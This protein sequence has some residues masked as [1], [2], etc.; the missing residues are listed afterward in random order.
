M[1]FQVVAAQIRW[2]QYFPKY[3][4]CFS[5]K[6]SHVTTYGY[7]V[8]L[9]GCSCEN[10]NIK[11]WSYHSCNQMTG[12]K[13]RLYWGCIYG[14]SADGAI[15]FNRHVTSF[16]FCILKAETACNLIAFILQESWIT[17]TGTKPF[18]QNQMQGHLSGFSD[19]SAGDSHSQKHYVFR[20][21]FH[22]SVRLSIAFL[23]TWYLGRSHHNILK[24]T[25][26][27]PLFNTIAQ[28]GRLLNQTPF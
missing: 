27:S 4:S 28:V 3:H 19:A 16:F 5:L 23:W 11:C 25:L 8:Q 7:L 1:F 24:K 10:T 18:Y 20:L 9:M 12:K 2:A 22:L 6:W 14:V 13:I 21:S 26:F 17:C 15:T